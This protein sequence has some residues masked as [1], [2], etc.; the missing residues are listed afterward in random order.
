MAGISAES[1]AEIVATSA[2]IL[3]V[4]EMITES[5]ASIASIAAPAVVDVAMLTISSGS[6]LERTPQIGQ[7]ES[8]APSAVS[9]VDT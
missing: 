4:E 8:V 6:A 3:P 9:A 1:D 7:A 2:A 5:A